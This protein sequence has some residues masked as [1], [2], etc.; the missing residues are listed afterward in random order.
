[1]GSTAGRCAVELSWLWQGLLVEAIS[2][3]VFEVVVL[4]LLFNFI[5]QR[6][7]NRRM[8]AI[9]AAL[10]RDL[11]QSAWRILKHLESMGRTAAEYRLMGDS[12]E[13]SRVYSAAIN[14]L[15]QGIASISEKMPML[16]MALAK[17][18]LEKFGALV[19]YLEIRIVHGMHRGLGW[20]GTQDI[21]EI[22]EGVQGRCDDLFKGRWTP[23]LGPGVGREPVTQWRRIDD[24]EVRMVAMACMNEHGA[25]AAAFAASRV[26]ALVAAGDEDGVEAWRRVAKEIEAREASPIRVGRFRPNT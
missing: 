24:S 16:T 11:R 17:E 7:E 22:I 26:D 10:D 18:D 4:A 13:R 15:M 21:D 3:A 2:F 25:G 12:P 6:Q 8:R 23:P 19:E 20:L 14:D 1:M 5:L 9:R